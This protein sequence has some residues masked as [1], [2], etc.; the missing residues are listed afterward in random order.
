MNKKK[1]QLLLWILLCPV[2]AEHVYAD[3][4]FGSVSVQSGESNNARKSTADEINERQDQYDLSLGGE[5]S[6]SLVDFNAQY[7]LT[8]RNYAEETQENNNLL[9]GKSA[10]LI[11]KNNQPADLLIEHSR[12]TVLKKP[13]ATNLVE[14]QDEREITSVT[15]T[16]RGRISPVDNIFLKG[17]L[18]KV[19][20]Q[21]EDSKNSRRDGGVLGFEHNISTTDNMQILIQQT[22]V[23]FDSAPLEN[24]VYHS[25]EVTYST[26]LRQL[27]YTAQI[28]VNES[29]PENEDKVLRP[30]YTFDV[31]Y[32]SGSR[33]FSLGLL[34][35]LT[36]AS[37]GGGNQLAENE[38][39]LGTDSA[40]NLDR[41]ERK[42]ATLSWDTQAVCESC[43]FVIGAYHIRDHYLPLE[44][45]STQKG[46]NLGFNYSLSHRSSI[47]AT[48]IKGDSK[49]TD[50]TFGENFK[51]QTTRVAFS[52]QLNDR[53]SVG[54]HVNNE[55]R[56]SLSDGE[57]YSER[58]IGASM[59]YEF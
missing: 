48:F 34:Q 6:N 7:L 32:N 28:G 8:A 37:L 12:F 43:T 2:T 41:F 29:I 53:F 58:Y 40:H 9:E 13:D 42:R 31:I 26:K 16:L 5:M 44:Q 56:H 10:L 51:I 22:D 59:S 4:F 39:P 14:N 49:F 57:S 17:K 27:S 47:A 1:Y 21:E 23:K 45:T 38:Q 36:D 35:E 19:T 46:W 55:K 54:C 52:Y 30:K 15:P 11:G 50:I 25:A 20:Y 3:K 33:N 18:T 24:Y